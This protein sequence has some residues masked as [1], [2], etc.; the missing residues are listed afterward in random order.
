ME[1][2][3]DPKNYSVKGFQHT[4]MCPIWYEMSKSKM[5]QHIRRII[6]T[7]EAIHM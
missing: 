2:H 6:V 7:T 5:D 3:P 1:H 4:E